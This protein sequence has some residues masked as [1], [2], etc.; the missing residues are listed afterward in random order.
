LTHFAFHARSTQATDSPGGQSTPPQASRSGFEIGLQPSPLGGSFHRDDDKE[1]NYHT[2]ADVH[3]NI[4]E[5]TF[6][7]DSCDDSQGAIHPQLD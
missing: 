5:S 7:D 1:R 6:R 3:R 2:A 4:T